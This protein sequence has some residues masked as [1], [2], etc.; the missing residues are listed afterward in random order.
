MDLSYFDAPISPAAFEFHVGDAAITWGGNDRQAIEDISS[1]GFPGIQIRSNSVQEFDSGA[2]LREV[3]DKSH[4]N[5]GCLVERNMSIDPAIESSEIAKHVSNAK[6]LRDAEGSI[7]K[8]LMRS[9]R[10]APLWRPT[11]SV[12][13]RC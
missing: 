12:S 6:F 7:F 10:I 8:S 11:T 2:A 9:P 13:A 5:D 3:L 1:V 4:L